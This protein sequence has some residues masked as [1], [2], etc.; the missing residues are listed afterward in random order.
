MIDW[1][2]ESNGRL[3]LLERFPIQP[4]VLRKALATGLPVALSGPRILL[5]WCFQVLNV[6]KSLAGIE[7]VDPGSGG[8]DGC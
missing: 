8:E 3:L 7:M 4:Q 2:I 1:G 5:Q 6:A